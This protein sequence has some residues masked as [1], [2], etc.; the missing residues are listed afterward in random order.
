MHRSPFQKVVHQVIPLFLAGVLAQSQ[1]SAPSPSELR[2]LADKAYIYAY[3]LVLMEFTRRVAVQRGTAVEPNVFNH[4]AEFPNAKFRAVIRPNADTLYSSAWLDVSNEPILLH[5]PDT[6][7]RYYLMQ[8]MDAW[9]ETIAVPGKRT[10]GTG[11]GWFA[12][13]GPGWK[14][15]LPASV[16]RDHVINATT[17]MLWLLGRTQTN[18]A[19]DYEFVHGIQRGYQLMPLSRY[20]DG[21]R[22]SAR[23]AQRPAAAAIVPPPI[24]VEHLAP[25]EFFRIFADLLKDNPPHAGDDAMVRDLARIGIV[26]GQQFRV[27]SLS[28]ESRQAL[29]QGAQDAAAR[30]AKMNGSL[31]RSGPTGWTGGKGSVGRYGIDYATRAFVAKIGLGANP[32][33]DATYLHCD[34]DASGQHLTG[35]KRYTIHST[36]RRCRRCAPS[37]RSRC[38][39][40]TDISP[41]IRS[42]RYAIGD[43]DALKYNPD[44]SLDLYLQNTSPGAAQESNWLPVPAGA[45]NLSLRLYWPKEEILSGK[46]IAPAV[47]VQN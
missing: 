25:A 38:T 19:A 30:L 4:V 3:P 18:S 35:S 32:P 1:P 7:D 46:W 44:G 5:V 23:P 17:N 24:Q 21:P 11:E 6:K 15:T 34:L 31:G 47:R 12:I 39:A 16:A 43:R 45:F 28:A 26:S 40:T 33:E 36:K 27:E 2:V 42:S 9:T 13:V 22:A 20:P 37:G 29:D 14:G 10:T 8:L 41:R